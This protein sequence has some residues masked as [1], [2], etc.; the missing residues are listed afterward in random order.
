[1]NPRARNLITATGRGHRVALSGC[2][3]MTGA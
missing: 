1:M 3:G 2:N